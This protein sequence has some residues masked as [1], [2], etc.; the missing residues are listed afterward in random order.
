MIHDIDCLFSC[1]ACTSGTLPCAWCPESHRCAYSSNVASPS[2]CINEPYIYATSVNAL[3][4]NSHSRQ[5]GA[6][7]CP[8]I[9]LPQVVVNASSGSRKQVRVYGYN[10]E[11]SGR[12]GYLIHMVLLCFV[13]VWLYHQFLMIYG[14]VLPVF[15]VNIGSGNGLLPD[16]TKPLPEP[17]LTYHK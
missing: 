17:M 14:N 12:S 10:I 1:S 9:S 15:W 11:V 6:A 3:Q 7:L 5:A 4:R 8:R 16:G 13:L 2:M